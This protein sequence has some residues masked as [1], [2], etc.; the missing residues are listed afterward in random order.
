MQ[1]S[2]ATFCHCIPSTQH[3]RFG[4]TKMQ[5]IQLLPLNQGMSFSLA[6]DVLTAGKHDETAIKTHDQEPLLQGSIP[7]KVL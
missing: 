4:P 3:T 5:R 6:D 1:L 7:L 2:A